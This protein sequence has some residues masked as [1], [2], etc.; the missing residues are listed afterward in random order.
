MS[1]FAGSR[2]LVAVEPEIRHRLRLTLDDCSR[3]SPGTV[4]M[5]CLDSMLATPTG[6]VIIV[7]VV[8]AVPPTVP[9][10]RRTSALSDRVTSP[11]NSS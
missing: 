7:A 5:D 8:V 6:D 1:D 3:P 11:G 10:T 2:F 4:S 9:P